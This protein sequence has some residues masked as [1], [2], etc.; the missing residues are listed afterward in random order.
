LGSEASAGLRPIRGPALDLPERAVARMA[1][2]G[3]LT[4]RCWPDL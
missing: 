1:E 3:I 2:A 4:R